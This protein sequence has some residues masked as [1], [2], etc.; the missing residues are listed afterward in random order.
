MD[1]YKYSYIDNFDNFYRTGVTNAT[2]IAISGSEEKLTYRFG[3][4]NNMEKSI[5]PNSNNRQF[6]I[7]MN[8]TYD[9]FKNLHFTVNANYVFEKF[10]SEE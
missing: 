6:G 5:L 2:S 1:I 3:V 8:T 10:I 4:S 9:I 7:N